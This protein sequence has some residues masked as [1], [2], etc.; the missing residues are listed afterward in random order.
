M[1]KVNLGGGREFDG[2]DWWN[3]DATSGPQPI[4]FSEHTQYH[5]P[6]ASIDLAYSSHTLEHLND[7]TIDQMLSQLHGGLKPQGTLILKIPDF[8]AV[9]QAYRKGDESFFENYRWGLESILKT[10]EKRGVRPTTLYKA[11]MIFCGF[12]TGDLPDHFAGGVQYG[13]QSYHGPAPLPARETENIL[14]LHTPHKISSLLSNFVR[15]TEPNAV[16]NHQNA[17]SR[18]ELRELFERS[19][20]RILSLDRD[21]IIEKFSDTVPTLARARS[22]SLYAM[23]QKA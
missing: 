14:L 19:G 23:I 7:A 11:S 15:S 2:L 17:W 1:L 9:L 13:E 6:A 18:E 10:W 4:R 16:F 5:F 3:L 8:E 22:E 21:Y 20:L 12:W